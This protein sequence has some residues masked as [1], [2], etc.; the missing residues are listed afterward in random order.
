MVS[1]TPEDIFDSVINLVSTNRAI[2]DLDLE[3]YYHKKELMLRLFE[4]I[5]ESSSIKKLSL[6]PKTT[7]VPITGE[8]VSRNPNICS[9]LIEL[10]LSN[11]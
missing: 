4:N 11:G 9:N 3:L 6:W 10:N 2:E 8:I 1:F 7:L 5:N